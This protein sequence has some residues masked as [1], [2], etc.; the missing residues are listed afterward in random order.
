MRNNG[1]MSA[2]TE[3]DLESR[4]RALEEEN[5]RLT[6]TLRPRASG[7]WWRA[8]LSAV[9]IVVATILVPTSVV[10]T[11]T[12][13]ELVSEDAFVATLSPLAHDPA[14]QTMIIDEISSA[15]DA[16]VDFAAVT[17]DVFDG[18][19]SLGLPPRA[20]QALDLLR[21]PAAQGVQSL[22]DSAVDRVVRS[23][24]F[25]EVWDLALRSAH[26][27]LTTAATSSGG[28]VLVLT[29]DGLGV[30]L[31]PIIEEVKGRLVTAGVG[32]ATFIPAIDKVIIIGDGQ[33][34]VAA[35]TAYVAADIV[36]WWL[37][38][39]TIA[40]FVG[41]VLI[42]RR[43]TV[44]VI[45]TGVG[46][47]IGG[48]ILALSFALGSAATAIVAGQ[49][50]LDPT[51]LGVIYAQLT[52]SM[53]QSAWAVAGLGFLVAAL[54]W[55]AGSSS[56]GRRTRHAV[57]DVNAAARSA[58]AARGLD[59]GRVGEVLARYRVAVRGVVIALGAIWLFALRPLDLGDVVVVLVITLIVTWVL[60]LLQKRPEVQTA[61]AS[62][63]DVSPS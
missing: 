20:A 38:V 18:V 41:A 62:A 28:G 17:D 40:L 48:S 57:S 29:D 59:T 54:G 12:R 6:S 11:W 5:A 51:A 58:L 23:D 4:I 45:G 46:L 43:R 27:S 55:L 21:A 47:L 7:G 53:T 49:A 39:L 14:V 52:S 9:M 63:D 37:P 15:I 30:S 33:A 34:L 24:A 25:A 60:E 61:A 26:R 2:A 3:N 13:I 32:V 1:A 36:G 22:V 56:S 19:E 31:A 10:A 35:R 8:L 44:A 50:A 42:A 16:Q